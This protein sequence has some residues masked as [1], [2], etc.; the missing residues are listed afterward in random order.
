MQ[1]VQSSV[2]ASLL[3][4]SK[5]MSNIEKKVFA[6]QKNVD[7]MQKVAAK[8]GTAGPALS[9][10]IRRKSPQRKSPSRQS[11]LRN[12]LPKTTGDVPQASRISAAS[13]ETFKQMLKTLQKQQEQ[14]NQFMKNTQNDL[15]SMEK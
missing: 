11:P 12:S 5:K 3:A 1:Q 9:E 7:S 6:T 2:E 10:S 8:S 15:K 4:I 13:D 14:I